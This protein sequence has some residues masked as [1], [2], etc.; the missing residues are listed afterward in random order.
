MRIKKIKV[1]HLTKLSNH[2]TK[3]FDNYFAGKWCKPFDKDKKIIE[4]KKHDK[5]L[6]LIEDKTLDFLIK[7][8]N[9]YHS[10]NM[11]KIFGRLFYYG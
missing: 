8:L 3:N 6:R 5:N 7:K 11:T 1:I 9:L 4:H 10:V 2:L